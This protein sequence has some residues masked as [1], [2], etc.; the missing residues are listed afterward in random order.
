MSPVCFVFVVLVTRLSERT[1]MTEVDSVH[2]HMFLAA[3]RQHDLEEDYRGKHVMVSIT[4][5]TLLEA[6]VDNT[7][8][9]LRRAAQ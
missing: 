7:L 1:L 2:T 8:D 9:A 3:R 5:H 4:K 6:S